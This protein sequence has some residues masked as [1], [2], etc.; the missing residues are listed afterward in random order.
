MLIKTGFGLLMAVLLPVSAAIA[1]TS[2]QTGAQNVT[3][4]LDQ[5]IIPDADVSITVEIADDNAERA[6]GLMFRET[7]APETGMLFIFEQPRP[8]S[9]WMKNTLI[10]LDLLFIDDTGEIRRIHPN[11]IPHD[12]TPIPGAAP[13]DPAPERLMVLEIGGGEAERLGIEEGMTVAHP[14]FATDRAALPCN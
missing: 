2:D 12:E 14:G 10:P 1:Q 9:F 11:A 8:A 7:L 13:N 3:C 5:A 4:A 6:L